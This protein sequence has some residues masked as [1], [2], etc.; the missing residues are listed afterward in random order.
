MRIES[1]VT[2]L[3]QSDVTPFPVSI[4]SSDTLPEYSSIAFHRNLYLIKVQS[5]ANA[6]ALSSCTD[7]FLKECSQ[8][9]QPGPTQTEEMHVGIS[10]PTLHGSKTSI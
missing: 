8:G 10:F 2:R 3:K 9:T 4:I 6:L 7:N 1:G 5:N